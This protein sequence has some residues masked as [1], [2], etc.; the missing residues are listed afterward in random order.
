MCNGEY[1]KHL[2]IARQAID[3]CSSQMVVL[4][5][6][7]I[8]R[9]NFRTRHLRIC[10][11][12]LATYLTLNTVVFLLLNNTFAE[13]SKSAINFQLSNQAF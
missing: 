2:L 11:C 1:A 4:L 12:V 3:L 9:S 6:V 13:V 10:L 5:E 7:S 8:K